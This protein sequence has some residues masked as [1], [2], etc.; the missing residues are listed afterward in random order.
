MSG[1][2]IRLFA[3]PQARVQLHLSLA[4]CAIGCDPCVGCFARFPD[5][6]RPR[7][8]ARGL[9]VDRTLSPLVGWVVARIPLRAIKAAVAALIERLPP[10]ATLVVFV[11]PVVL[12]LPLKFLGLWMLAHGLG[13]ARLALLALA[14]VAGSASPPSSST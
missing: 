1:Q 8:P 3:T 7:L 13:S 9:A 10:A 14:K 12:L 5:P 4:L 2:P 6:P 11:V